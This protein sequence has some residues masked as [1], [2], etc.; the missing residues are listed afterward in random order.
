MVLRCFPRDSAASHTFLKTDPLSLR[1]RQ[2]GEPWRQVHCQ[3]TCHGADKALIENLIYGLG[4]TS[5]IL[6]VLK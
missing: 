5:I 3:V 6:L 4:S 2:E 1:S